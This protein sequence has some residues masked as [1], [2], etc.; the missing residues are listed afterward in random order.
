MKTT[1]GLKLVDY[2]EIRDRIVNDTISATK[3]VYPD[4]KEMIMGVIDLTTSLQCAEISTEFVQDLWGFMIWSSM[5]DQDTS[6]TLTTII[7][8]LAEF[9][10]NRNEGW[11]SPRSSGYRKFLTGAS[12]LN[13]S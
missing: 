8:D 7:H 9:S 10:K 2:M 1:N 13:V 4:D 11:F 12:V 3:A 6:E 5:T